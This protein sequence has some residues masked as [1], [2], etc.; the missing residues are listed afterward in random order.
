MLA[1]LT[2]HQKTLH[3][4]PKKKQDIYCSRWEQYMYYGLYTYNVYFRLAG[5]T[6]L[7]GGNI[8]I[9]QAN[10]HTPAITALFI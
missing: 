2:K 9:G 1:V 8:R 10:M 3:S 4:Y 5:Q 6:S 7:G